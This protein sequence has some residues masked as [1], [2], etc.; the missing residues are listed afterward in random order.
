MIAKAIFGSDLVTSCNIPYLLPDRGTKAMTFLEIF[1]ACIGDSITEGFKFITNVFPF[2]AH[3]ALTP[4]HRRIKKNIETMHAAIR[5]ILDETK[6]A[7]SVYSS[8][9]E[10][11][12]DKELMIHD[13]L[14]LLMAGFDTSA[15]TITTVVYRSIK[16]PDKFAHYQEELKALLKDPE[17]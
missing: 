11:Y 15:H 4:V 10:H 5:K 6:D 2:L 17:K 16:H 7:H 8:I 1:M 9:N 12:E 3:Y 13:L 14:A